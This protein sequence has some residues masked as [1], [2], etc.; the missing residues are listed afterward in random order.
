MKNQAATNMAAALRIQGQG[1]A[2]KIKAIAEAQKEQLAVLGEQAT[3]QLAMF[4]KFVAALK[5]RAA[6][7]DTPSPCQSRRTD[8]AVPVH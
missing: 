5:S 3:V 1:E 7:G 6:L 2:D 8:R 4:D